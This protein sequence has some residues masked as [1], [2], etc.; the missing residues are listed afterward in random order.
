MQDINEIDKV[1]KRNVEL[2]RQVRDLAQEN[3]ALYEENKDLRFEKE[4]LED[5]L[6]QINK[7]TISN[8]YNNEQA[9]FNK[10]KELVE[11]ANQN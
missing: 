5:V 10:I 1:H 7:L 2:A 9:I 6:K 3:K 11:T 4:E 8:K